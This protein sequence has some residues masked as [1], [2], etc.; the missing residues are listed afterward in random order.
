MLRNFCHFNFIYEKQCCFPS[1]NFF[2]Y[3]L[4]YVVFCKYLEAPKMQIHDHKLAN[5][6]SRVF[7]IFLSFSS[8][9]QFI[10][11]L[12]CNIYSIPYHKLQRVLLNYCHTLSSRIIVKECQWCQV[13]VVCY[14]KARNWE[15][16]KLI[17]QKKLKKL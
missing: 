1:L 17:N 12:N 8:F 5:R 6:I 15:C 3:F 10:N 9:S 14:Y 13:F 16:V 7:I 2:Q 4:Q 11:K